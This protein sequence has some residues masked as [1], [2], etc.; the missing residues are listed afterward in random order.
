MMDSRNSSAQDC[1]FLHHCSSF[2]HGRSTKV[3]NLHLLPKVMMPAGMPVPPL[4]H[5]SSRYCAYDNNQIN[6][7][8]G[9][10]TEFRIIVIS[11]PCVRGVDDKNVE[12][13]PVLKLIQRMK[14]YGGGHTAPPFL[15]LALDGGDWPVS[16]PDSFTTG[17]RAPSTHWI[18]GWAGPRV[19]LDA[20]KN[21]KFLPCRE[22]NLGSAARTRLGTNY[23]FY[24]NI[25]GW[26]PYWVHSALRPLLAYCTCP[27]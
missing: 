11:S 4:P 25:S 24:L 6:N 5:T 12:V 26:S 20:V 8:S 9:S 22:S 7:N 17:K 1:H 15:T 19:D 18:G 21:R 10:Q 2:Q 23:F 13:L 16:R 3:A 14:T 27:G